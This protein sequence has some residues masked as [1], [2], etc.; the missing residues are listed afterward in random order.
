[1]KKFLN[2]RIK[3]TSQKI[4]SL[5]QSLKSKS[6]DYKPLNKF[7][8]LVN[9]QIKVIIDDLKKEKKELQQALKNKDILIYEDQDIIKVQ[10]NNKK[11]INKYKKIRS[12]IEKSKNFNP[13]FF[14]HDHKIDKVIEKE[15]EDHF[16]NN[17]YD[18]SSAGT[19]EAWPV[20]TLLK[21]AMNIGYKLGKNSKLY[22]QK[23]QKCIKAL[24][25]SDIFDFAYKND[26]GSEKHI[27]LFKFDY[28]HIDL[29]NKKIIGFKNNKA[30]ESSDYKLFID[31]EK[32]KAQLKNWA[33]KLNKVK[34]NL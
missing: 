27:Q 32:L 15:F 26:S 7:G 22:N 19:F 31:K 20:M 1:M 23:K 16:S 5:E 28:I 12:F 4:K 9:I 30:V 14:S 24:A 18:E 25:Y 11:I 2:Q 10:I 13:S 3:V 8:N 17:H 21:Q 6:I 29:T 33:N 34:I